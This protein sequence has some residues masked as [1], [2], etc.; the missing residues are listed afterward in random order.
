M[1][2]HNDVLNRQYNNIVGALELARAELNQQLN[3]CDTSLFTDEDNKRFVEDLES[4]LDYI[5]TA[6]DLVEEWAVKLDSS[7]PTSSF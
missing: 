1:K 5:N 4:D 3:S 2:L 7:I 6:I